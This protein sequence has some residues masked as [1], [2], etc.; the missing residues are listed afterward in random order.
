MGG[1]IAFIVSLIKGNLNLFNLIY[2]TFLLSVLFYLFMVF[3]VSLNTLTYWDINFFDYPLLIGM[4]RRAAG[5]YKTYALG[6][7]ILG[8][9]GIKRT[10]DSMGA[11]TDKAAAETVGGFLLTITSDLLIR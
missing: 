11:E 5:S 9:W 8:T 4:L 1:V 6:G 3:W 2:S 10:A 7:G